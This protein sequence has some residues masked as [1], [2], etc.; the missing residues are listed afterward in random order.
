MITFKQFKSKLE[1]NT[2]S[3]I[4][5]SM[6]TFESPKNFKAKEVFYSIPVDG[7]DI[8]VQLTSE[9][10]DPVLEDNNLIKVAFG[11]LLKTKPSKN[12]TQESWIKV[13]TEELLALKNPTK[14]LSTVI[15]GTLTDFITKYFKEDSEK[16]LTISFH[17]GLT[18]AEGDK[19]VEISDSKRS[20]IYLAMLKKLPILKK[21]NL[22]VSN[23]GEEGIEITNDN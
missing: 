2:L 7:I 18:D 16:I 4:F 10:A 21:Y 5:D 12:W 6:Y 11:R 1:E 22:T 19:N 14:L 8:K 17:G 15:Y 20:R 9:Y 3:E 13:D 23:L